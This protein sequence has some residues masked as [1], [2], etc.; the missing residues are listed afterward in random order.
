MLSLGVPNPH[1]LLL[2][3]QLE[4]ELMAAMLASVSRF[5]LEY[6]LLRL[7]LPLDVKI[8]RTELKSPAICLPPESY[9]LAIRVSA[10]FNV[11]GGWAYI[12]S[13][14]MLMSLAAATVICE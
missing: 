3:H 9:W 13:P 8:P 1:L 4:S 5:P 14:V 6:G 12:R 11:T 7:M 2:L 10:A